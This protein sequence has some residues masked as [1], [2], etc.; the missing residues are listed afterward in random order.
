MISCG[1]CLDRNLQTLNRALQKLLYF[2]W[3]RYCPVCGSWVRKFNSYGLACRADAQCPV[4]QSLERHRFVWIFFQQQ[5]CLFDGQPK[6][7]LHFA[8]EPEFA[9]KFKKIRTLEYVTA[10]LLDPDVSLKTD[11]CQIDCPDESFDIV[12]CSHVLEHV[13][14]DRKAI[15]EIYRVLK[16][17]GLAVIL[18]PITA[19]T[20]FEDPSITDPHLREQMFGQ[21]DHVRR[22][23]PDFSKR[24]VAQNFAVSA[25]CVSDLLSPQQAERM[26]LAAVNERKMPVFS[27]RKL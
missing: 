21:Y 5:T 22:Y 9:R 13:Q 14:D 8:P 24:L 25:V 19:E 16:K 23:G 6:R 15:A 18:V 3:N 2:G 26:G 27:C 20:T 4:C 17:E 7:L 10:D 12:Y 1:L 11:I